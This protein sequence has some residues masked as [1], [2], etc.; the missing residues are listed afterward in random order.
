[1]SHVFINYLINWD[2][3]IPRGIY[4]GWCQKRSREDLKNNK[5]DKKKKKKTQQLQKHVK[6]MY[7]FRKQELHDLHLLFLKPFRQGPRLL[8]D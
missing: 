6:Y 2:N 7:F 3:L 4:V 8:V 5:K 1:M